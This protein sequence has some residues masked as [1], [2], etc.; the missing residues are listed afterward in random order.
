MKRCI[1]ILLACVLATAVA[2]I[3]LVV[4]LLVLVTMGWPV[5]FAQARAGRHERTIR[6]IKFR[7]MCPGSDTDAVRV[8]PLGRALRATS[9]DELPSLWLV[10]VG[11]MSLV[12]PRPLPIE[13][14]PLYSKRQRTRHRVRP[15]LTGWSQVNGRNILT[16]EDRL[17]MDAWYAEH[18]SLWLDMRILLRTIPVVISMRGVRHPGQVTMH[19]FTGEGS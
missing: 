5:F 4:A 7:T 2:P 19:P 12:G 10:F 3:M 16:W 13:Y 1:D 15:G 8:T 6:V 9:L 11:D 18:R 17:E 14:L